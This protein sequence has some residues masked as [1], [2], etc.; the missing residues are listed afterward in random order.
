MT[1]HISEE[2]RTLAFRL[3]LGDLIRRQPCHGYAC[4]CGCGDCVE[5]E[6][7]ARAPKPQ[8]RQPWELAA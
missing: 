2:A 7:L 3:K 8:V 6:K 1:R 4:G 5:R